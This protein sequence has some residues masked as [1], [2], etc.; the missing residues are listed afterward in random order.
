MRK[1][2]LIEFPQGFFDSEDVELKEVSV[3]PLMIKFLDNPSENVQLCA[4]TRNPN[5]IKYIKTPHPNP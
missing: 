1:K 3:F 4:F 5:V 2:M